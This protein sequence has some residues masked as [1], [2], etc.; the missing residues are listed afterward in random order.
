MRRMA[1]FVGMCMLAAAPAVPAWATNGYQL[2]GV[3][4]IQK[5]MAGAVTAAPMDTM[6]AISNPAGM[7]RVGERADFSMEAFMPKRRVSFPGNG[8]TTEGGSELYGVPSVG[9]LAGA[10]DRDNVYFGGGMF[11]TSGLGVDYDQVRMANAGD[12]GGGLPVANVDFSGYSAIQFWKMAPTIA[13]NQTDALSFGVSLDLDYQSIT[14]FQRFTN[15]AGG[16]DVNFDLGR[17]TNQLGYGATVGVLYD[18]T[19]AVTLGASYATKQVFAQGIYRLADGDISNYGVAGA[20]P[21]GQYRMGLDYPQQ[22]NLGVAVRPAERVVVDFD[23]KWINWSSTHDTVNLKGP[24]GTIP[25]AFGWDDQVVYALGAQWGATDALTL[26]A[27]FN[28]AKAPIDQADVM[29]NLIFPAVVEKHAALGLDYRLGTHWGVGGAFMKAFK[30]SV[31]GVGDVPAG[32]QPLL[33][34]ATSSGATISLEETS[35]GVLLYYLI[36]S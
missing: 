1:V 9:W 7:A 35:V 33:N 19:P 3:G 26:R 21:A 14:M 32:F 24:A 2:I 29:N 15:I 25:L 16:A 6:T 8:G 5:S 27:G 13:W 20:A 31:T 17:P 18:V 36:G 10:F 23:V 30:E 28:Y 34:G 12:F 22:L 11:A 4:Q